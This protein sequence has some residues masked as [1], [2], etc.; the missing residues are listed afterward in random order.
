M[1]FFRNPFRKKK[2]ISDWAYKDEYGY[3]HYKDSGKLIHRQRA[4]SQIYLPN[5]YKY[6]LP[7]TEYEVHHRD[8]NKNNN[9]LSN[10]KVYTR[11]QHRRHHI[12]YGT[13]KAIGG[14]ART[15]TKIGRMLR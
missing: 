5:R 3:W 4:Y 7:W 14:V 1:G 8:G 15:I 2:K 9:R 13:F 11:S 6:K 10:L 12:I